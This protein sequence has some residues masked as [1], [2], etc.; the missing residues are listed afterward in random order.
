MSFPAYLSLSG[1]GDRRE[2]GYSSQPAERAYR[3]SMFGKQDKMLEK[4][5]D[6]LEVTKNG[7]NE[8]KS[9]FAEVK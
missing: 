8:M 7:F 2:A 3:A 1:R 9:G 4:Q 5:D 6:L